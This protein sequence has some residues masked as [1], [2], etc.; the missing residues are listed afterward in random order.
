MIDTRKRFKVTY[1]H[2]MYMCARGIHDDKHSLTNDNVY[3]GVFLFTTSRTV[4]T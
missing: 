4:Q 3:S 1:T 2:M